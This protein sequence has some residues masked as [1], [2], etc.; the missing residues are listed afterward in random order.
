MKDPIKFMRHNGWVPYKKENERIL[1][2]CDDPTD[3]RKISDI[4]LVLGDTQFDFIVGLRRDI[5]RLIDKLTAQP[6]MSFS[7]VESK[8]MEKKENIFQEEKNEINEN[9]SIIAKFVNQTIVHA[10]SKGASDIHVET[11]PGKENTIIRLREDGDCYLYEEVPA[12]WKKALVS[13]IKIMANLNIAERRLPQDGKIQLLALGKTI[14][15]RVAIIPTHGGYEDVVMRILPDQEPVP[16]DKLNLSPLNNKLFINSVNK[17]HG[18]FLVVGPTGSGKTTT[19]HSALNHINRPEL[20]IWTAEDPV[21]ITQKGLRQVQI[22]QNINLTFSAALRAFLRAD[23]DVI[24]IGE[25][26]DHETA[27][28]GIGA[29]LTGHLVFSTLHTNSAAETVTRLIDLGIDTLNI[30]DALQGVLAQRLTKT[31]CPFCKENYRPS[32]GEMDELASQYGENFWSELKETIESNSMCKPRGCSRCNNSGFKGRTGIH[33][34]LVMNQ[35]MKKLIQQKAPAEQ[36]RESAIKNGMRT[37]KQDGI[38]KV[39]KGD[40]TFDR[41]RAVCLV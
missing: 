39:L 40:T 26:R 22:N 17:P 15:L 41:V 38:W 23:P 16:L 31:L 28:M 2:V 12:N 25:M 24:M 19:L 32:A 11:C 18:I 35:E 21:E 1:I 5:V 13:R 37:L 7:Q 29:S 33:E 20:K 4:Q 27:N 10:Y 8:L 36:I 3:E 14:E 6:K 9:D 34:I 30:G